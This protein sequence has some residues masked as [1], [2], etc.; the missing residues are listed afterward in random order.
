MLVSELSGGTSNT[1]AHFQAARQQAVSWLFSVLFS[2]LLRE[3]PT[4][5]KGDEMNRKEF[6]N[7][8]DEALELPAGTL[9]GPEELSDLDMWDSMAMMSY[10]ALADNNGSVKISPRQ[11]VGCTTVDDLLKLAKVDD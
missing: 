7:A 9:Q 2:E 5:R 6:L 1:H 3:R 4:I 8:L 11:I 10:I